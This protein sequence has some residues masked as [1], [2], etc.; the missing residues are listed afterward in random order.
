MQ[1]V[2][3]LETPDTRIALAAISRQWFDNPQKELCILGGYRDKRKDYH[4]LDDLED[5]GCRRL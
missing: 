3:V 2:C 1:E 5:A 4:S